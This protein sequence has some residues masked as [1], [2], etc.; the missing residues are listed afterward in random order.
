MYTDEESMD[1][2]EESMDIAEESMDVAD[3]CSMGVMEIDDSRPVDLK[4]EYP[5]TV[6]DVH[7]RILKWHG[8]VL[9]YYD[10]YDTILKKYVPKS[11]EAI[12]LELRDYYNEKI[13][14]AHQII[15]N[16]GI[17]VYEWMLWKN[18]YDKLLV[19]VTKI[20]EYGIIISGDL[21]MF[22]LMEQM[23]KVSV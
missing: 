20:R 2:A 11:F 8:K 17:S 21:D 1:I 16:P 14:R 15:S 19:Y 7:R 22:M 9:G 23:R 5:L 10:Y 6:E 3:D 13:T 18:R 4:P 12:F